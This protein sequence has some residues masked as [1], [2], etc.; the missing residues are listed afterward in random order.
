MKFSLEFLKEFVDIKEKPEEIANKLTLVGL[1][2]GQIEKVDSDVSFDAEVT[3][4]RPDLLSIFGIAH[5]V[6]ALTGQRVKTRNQL[7]EKSFSRNLDV[8]IK[9]KS[10]CS[11][12]LGREIKGV[13]VKPSPKWLQV[14]LAA[15]GISSVNN[16]VDITNYCMLKWGQPLHAFDLKI[17]D[18]KIIIRRAR[19]GESLLCIDNKERILNKQHLVVADVKKALA[20]AGII[21]G[22]ESEI[23]NRTTDIFLEAAIFSPLVIRRSRRSLGIDTDSS[24]RFERQVNPFYLEQASKEAVDLICE[25][26]KGKAVSYVK[27]GSLPPKEKKKIKFNSEKM[28]SILGV[29]I[30]KQEAIK[31]LKSIGC[32]VEKNKSSFSIIPPLFRTD[33]SIPEDIVEEIARIWGYENIPAKLPALKRNSEAKKSVFRFKNILRNKLAGVGFD[34]IITISIISEEDRFLDKKK[35]NLIH[36]NN[37]L[38][39]NENVLRTDIYPGMINCIKHNVDRKQYSLKFFE[40]ADGFTKD[41]K[42]F[43]ESSRICLGAHS[44]KKEDF[45]IFKGQVERFL[46]SLG[47][48]NIAWKHAESEE[49]SNYCT[50]KDIGWCGIL[51][52]KQCNELGLKEVFIAEFASERLFEKS[53]TPVYK[54]I[55]Y[56]P[57]I[58]RDVSIGLRKD[59]Q[60]REIEKIIND[61][62]KDL[63]KGYKIVDIYMGKKIADDSVGITLRL[64]YQHKDRTLQSEEVDNIHFK[65][66]DAFGQKEGVFLR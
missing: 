22:K 1:E 2:V 46:S 61:K 31:I 66:R 24:Y 53:Y 35:K 45:F 25:L 52:K 57:W 30:K 7:R 47:I 23:N 6:A 41:R 16:I 59:L 51:S 21:G 44:E 62:A 54:K 39:A 64:S 12:Y 5:E 65:V 18:E 37:P 28:N 32:E 17:I 19:K 3:S 42:P 20:V 10:D 33:I 11:L 27:K 14:R 56:Y 4:N 63:L 58:E 36:I 8:E 60:F 34:E 9:D 13:Q 50:L 38:R 48:K 26:G 55:N 49:F 40:I 15:C 29:K 43:S